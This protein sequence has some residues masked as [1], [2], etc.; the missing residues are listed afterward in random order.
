MAAYSMTSYNFNISFTVYVFS[1]I[2]GHHR[3]TWLSFCQYFHWTNQ[4]V[5]QPK[6]SADQVQVTQPWD[7]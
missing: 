4:L 5:S 2:F 6:H 1:P 3:L 7:K